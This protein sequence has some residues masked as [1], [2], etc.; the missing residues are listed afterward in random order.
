MVRWGAKAG[1]RRTR[2]GTRRTRSTSPT[3]QQP[4]HGT[5]FQWMATLIDQCASLAPASTTLRWGP[6]LAR[7]G[8]E[9][10][11][12][13]DG[14]TV[15]SDCGVQCPHPIGGPSRSRVVSREWTAE[16]RMECF[17]P[18]HRLAPG[19]TNGAESLV[20]SHCLPAR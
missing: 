16:P 4:Q 19:A 14:P 13:A 6:S 1:A 10:P 8:E 12:A 9:E 2:R 15:S 3:V 18:V 7:L 20:L 5:A 11:C 17:S